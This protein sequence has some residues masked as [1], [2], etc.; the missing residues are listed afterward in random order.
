MSLASPS[1]RAFAVVRSSCRQRSHMSN[2]ANSD[3][4]LVKV[5]GQ[6]KKRH[7]HLARQKAGSLSTIHLKC[8]LCVV[9]LMTKTRSTMSSEDDCTAI[10]TAAASFASCSSVAGTAR[11]ARIAMHS[12]SLRRRASNAAVAAFA[13]EEAEEP[14]RELSKRRLTSHVMALSGASA[15]YLKMVSDAHLARMAILYVS[16]HRLAQY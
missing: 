10:C 14:W 6:V 5:W 4:S 1:C 3:N 7:P 9:S 15:T 13:E 11:C 16:N 8:T 12:S 2:H